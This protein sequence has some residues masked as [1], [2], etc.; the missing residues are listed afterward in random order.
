MSRADNWTSPIAAT[1][2]AA[3]PDAS[4]AA[5]SRLGYA[6]PD[7]MVAAAERLAPRLGPSPTILDLACG[8]GTFGAVLRHYGS[9]AALFAATAAG[10]PLPPRRQS[11]LGAAPIVGLDIAAPAVRFAAS[12]GFIDEGLTEDL[13]AGPPSPEAAARLGEAD[14]VVEVGAEWTALGRLLPHLLPA[15]RR[16]PPL[17]LGPRGDAPTGPVFAAL[18][19]G[20]YEGQRLTTEPLRFRRFADADERAAA[21]RREA[22]E[23]AT[24]ASDADGYRM[25][26]FLFAPA[27]RPSGA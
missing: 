12:A 17:L 21:G 13:A 24:A 10:S 14:L 1:Y 3:T 25:H 23:G 27:A 6:A 20:G 18:A 26:I 11:P 19:A 22:L 8:Y 9:A 5:L 16:R 4:F 15:L 2:D 7:H